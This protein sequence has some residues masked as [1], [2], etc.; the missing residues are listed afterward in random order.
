MQLIIVSITATKRVGKC[1]Y[2]SECKVLIIYTAYLETT[3]LLSIAIDTDGDQI[4]H[5]QVI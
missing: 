4:L 2:F 3:T 5:I 1:N